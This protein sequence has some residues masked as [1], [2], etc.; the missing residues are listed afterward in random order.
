LSEIFGHTSVR[1][2]IAEKWNLPALNRRDAAATAPLGALDLMSAP[3]FL[4]PPEPPEPALKW[5]ALVMKWG[6]C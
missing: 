1:K 5:G 4:T 2:L 6:I 3:A